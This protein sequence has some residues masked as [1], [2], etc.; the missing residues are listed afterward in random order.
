MIIKL[1]KETNEI[2][3]IL[4]FKNCTMLQINQAESYI[5]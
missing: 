3:I 1:L 5:L 2:Q 4:E